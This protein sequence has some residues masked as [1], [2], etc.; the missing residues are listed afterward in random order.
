MTSRAIHDAT[1]VAS[2]MPAAM[3]FVPSIG[4]ISHSYDEHT[5]DDDI[6][7]GARAFVGAAAGILLQQCAAPA[8]A[9]AAAS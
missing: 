2:V 1:P 3:L 7:V 5:Y 4:G 6:A 9:S 8:D